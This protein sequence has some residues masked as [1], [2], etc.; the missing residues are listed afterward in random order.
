MHRLLDVFGR[1][2]AHSRPIY[3]LP[4]S[5]DLRGLS[6]T[7]A[8]R[9]G[10]LA[11]RDNAEYVAARIESPPGAQ[12]GAR[13]TGP[14][15][16]RAHTYPER[17][18]ERVTGANQTPQLK[19]TTAIT[20]TALPL[21][22]AF[23]GCPSRAGRATGPDRSTPTH[24]PCRAPLAVPAQRPRPHSPL[25]SKSAIAAPTICAGSGSA[26]CPPRVTGLSG[27]QAC[28]D[29]PGVAPS[30]RTFSPTNWQRC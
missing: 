15:L 8:T 25:R 29:R 14:L 27:P 22:P 18:T 23:P 24:P 2:W 17:V 5:P 28:P 9:W 19:G 7:T 16:V 6:I 1:R 12:D 10:A 26:G 4:S 11:A 20:G 3:R 21:H 13:V 30:L